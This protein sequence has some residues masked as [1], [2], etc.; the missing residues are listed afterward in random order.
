MHTLYPF[1]VCEYGESSSP[2]GMSS[3]ASLRS[4]DF[5]R[6]T[7]RLFSLSISYPPLWKFRE[8]LAPKVVYESTGIKWIGV[9]RKSRQQ[10]QFSTGKSSLQQDFR[11]CLNALLS[12]GKSKTQGRRGNSA[13]KGQTLFCHKHHGHECSPSGYWGWSSEKL[14]SFSLFW[15]NGCCCTSVLWWMGTCF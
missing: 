5:Q 15:W 12:W 14:G 11:T 2:C 1:Q 4:Q 8:P 9:D 7:Q 6:P 3:N 13:S 10:P